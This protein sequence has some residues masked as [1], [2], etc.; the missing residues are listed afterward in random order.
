MEFTQEQLKTLLNQSILKA[1]HIFE[2][3]P[4]CLKIQGE[5]GKQIFATLGNFSTILARPKVGKTTFTSIAISSLLSE[6]KLLSFI[7]TL[8]EERK[9][10]LWIDTE[11]GKP[12]CIKT[13]RFVS[14]LINGNANDHP[15]NLYFFSFRQFNSSQRIQLT[16]YAINHIKN[17][18]FVVIDGIRDFVSSINDE[19]EATFIADKLLK[20][21]Q[22][23][24]I[25]ALTILH[26]NKGDANARGHLGTELMNKAETVAKLTRDESTGTRLTIVEPEFTRHK[27][28]EP[29]AYSID[30]L[31]NISHQEAIQEYQPSNPKVEELTHH[32]IEDLLRKTF[33]KGH[34]LNYTPLWT[35]MK[36]VLNTDLNIQ[37]GNGKSKELVT[38]LKSKSYLNYDSNLKVYSANLPPK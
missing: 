21:T 25:H 30:D 19:R 4:T 3:P 20:W 6:K 33:E 34:P 1:D 10:I 36:T 32:Q 15:K 23:K 17:L 26:Q 11:Q 28:F 18:V 29:F 5:F 16:E 13:I 35:T 14:K 31:G 38:F 2:A 8:P 27:D 22:E 24:N 12:E 9:N 37:F 7:P